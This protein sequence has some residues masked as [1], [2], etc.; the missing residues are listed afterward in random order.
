[1]QLRYWSLQVGS[2]THPLYCWR[3]WD[4]F[5]TAR[6]QAHREE[7]RLCIAGVGHFPHS[8]CKSMTTVTK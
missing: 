5:S 4:S 2:K 6:T 8:S 7:N 3:S 1:M